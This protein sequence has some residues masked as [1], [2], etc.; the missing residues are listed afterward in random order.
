M[1]NQQNIANAQQKFIIQIDS[2]TL[3]RIRPFD[4]TELVKCYI[5]MFSGFAWVNWTN[6]F[7]LGRAWQTALTQCGAFCEPKNNK[8]PAAKYLQATFRA[9]KKYW[10]QIIM[11]HKNRENTINPN[12]AHVKNLRQ[13][14]QRMIREAMDKINLI[15]SRYNEYTLDISRDATATM[16]ATPNTHAH[17]QRTLAQSEQMKPAQPAIQRG[18]EPQ[19]MEQ[20][21]AQPVQKTITAKQPQQRAMAQTAQTKSAQPAIQRVT[22]PQRMAQPAAQPLQKT[23]TAKQAQQRT[24]VQPVQMKPAQPAIQRVTEP[25]R[26]LQPAAQPVQKT[27]TAK[28]AQQRTLAQPVQ[29]K[30]AQ[31]TKPVQQKKTYVQPTVN[32][33]QATKTKNP[34]VAPEMSVHENQFAKQIT[35]QAKGQTESKVATFTTAQMQIKRQINI[36]ML[37]NINQRAA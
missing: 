6:K 7:S 32:I 28:Q 34:Y 1:T 24:L 29:M 27:I 16:Q 30:P 19:R 21:A 36:F 35:P 12:D 15:L 37:R 9:H 22:E 13:H 18:T 11:T 3:N 17:Q 33:A 10:S 26:M 31:I 8:N 5:Q 2:K 4:R 23:I 25:Q 14:G 20:P